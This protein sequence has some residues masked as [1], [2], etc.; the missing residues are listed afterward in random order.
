[1]SDDRSI[2]DLSQNSNESIPHNVAI[3]TTIHDAKSRN[4][5]YTIGF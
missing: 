5:R 4:K 3:I 1:M 2:Y